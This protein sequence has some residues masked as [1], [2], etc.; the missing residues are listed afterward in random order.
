MGEIGFFDKGVGPQGGHQLLFLDKPALF[1]DERY[2]RFES[3]RCECYRFAIA[4]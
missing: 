4:Q 2:E 3:L 1:F